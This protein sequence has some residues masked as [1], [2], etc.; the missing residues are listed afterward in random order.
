MENAGQN[1]DLAVAA[2]RDAAW[3]F[4]YDIR[5]EQLVDLELAGMYEPVKILCTALAAAVSAAAAFLGCEAALVKKYAPA[6]GIL[7][8]DIK[9]LLPKQ[10]IKE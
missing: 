10:E 9:N 3:N 4:G 1:A 2:V 6:P 8:P 5:K 7:S